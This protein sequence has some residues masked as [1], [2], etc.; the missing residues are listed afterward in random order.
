MTSELCDRNRREINIGLNLIEIF[1]PEKERRSSSGVMTMVERDVKVT[2]RFFK[3]SAVEAACL[4]AKVVYFR[5][6]SIRI[7]CLIH[8]DVSCARDLRAAM[9]TMKHF[10]SRLV[11]SRENLAK[12]DQL[13]LEFAA[14]LSS[15]IQQVSS[16][17][18]GV[19]KV[20][21]IDWPYFDSGVRTDA[22]AAAVLFRLYPHWRYCDSRL[23]VFDDTTG[24][25]G[26][27]ESTHF[28]I[29]NR[30]SKSLVVT[31]DGDT[32]YDS[33][34]FTHLRAYETGRNHF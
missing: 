4:A 13:N 6:K 5:S 29:I 30:Y 8:D 1:F 24:L 22:E 7:G 10:R 23:F 9:S 17:A 25:W 14:E 16:Y 11:E 33:A 32:E 28:L 15:V 34:P 2:Y 19:V 12:E 26:T 18:N 31:N 3:L 27:D 21:R 20:T